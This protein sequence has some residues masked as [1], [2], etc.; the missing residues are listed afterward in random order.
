MAPTEAFLAGMKCH[1]ERKESARWKRA[2]MWGGGI[3]HRLHVDHCERVVSVGAAR[4]GG[5]AV[6]VDRYLLGIFQND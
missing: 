2:G 4:M 3:S 1:R 5:G 6:F